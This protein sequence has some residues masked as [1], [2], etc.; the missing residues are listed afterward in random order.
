VVVIEAG[1]RVRLAHHAYGL[2][3]GGIGEQAGVTKVRCAEVEVE[4]D[5]A[6][7]WNVDGEIVESGSVVFKVDPEAVEVVVG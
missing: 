3:R 7:P 2:R 6:E 1:S 4:L 5:K